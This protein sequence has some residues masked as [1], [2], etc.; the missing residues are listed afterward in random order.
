MTM[1]CMGRTIFSANTG[2]SEM[3]SMYLQS[4]EVGLLHAI[5]AVTLG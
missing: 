5:R 2:A 3:G 4:L 1:A